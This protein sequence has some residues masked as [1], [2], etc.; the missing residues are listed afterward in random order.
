[1]KPI[2]VV[3]YDGR[4]TLTITGPEKMKSYLTVMPEFAYLI[5]GALE[6]LS[7]AMPFTHKIEINVPKSG[8]WQYTAYFGD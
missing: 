6:A 5:G 1:M 8:G 2:T 7:K 4:S 3:E